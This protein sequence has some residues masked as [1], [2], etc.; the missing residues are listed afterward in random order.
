M[1]EL[2][3]RCRPTGLLQHVVIGPLR[4]DTMV[5]NQV[6]LLLTLSVLWPSAALPF[7]PGNIGNLFGMAES[8]GRILQRSKRGWMWNQFFLLEEYSGNDHQYVGKNETLKEVHG[9]HGYNA[10]QW[11][12]H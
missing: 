6:A 3:N 12:K 11:K 1:L 8:D 9:H 10:R 2:V 7:T 4:S 5:A